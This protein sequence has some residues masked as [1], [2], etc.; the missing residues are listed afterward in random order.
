MKQFKQAR[1]VQSGMTLMEVLAALAIVAS[2]VVG[3]LS[4]F[5][6]AN[7]S[8]VSSQLQ[9]D[10]VALRTATQSAFTGQGGYGTDP[11]NGVLIASNKVPTSMTTN[12]TNGTIT[13]SLN[14]AVTVTGATNQF[15]VIV[16]AVPADVCTSLMT[17]LSAGWDSV[18]IGTATAIE[19]FP[20]S[21]AIATGA[22]GCQP[23]NN[24]ITWTTLS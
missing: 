5:G 4:L 20:V 3:S 18:K 10:I 21:P 13:T 19:V 17:G 11:L 8:S 14:G 6:A 22:N 16:T 7:S 24:T 9:K 12:S 1:Q 2:V 23:G 15:T